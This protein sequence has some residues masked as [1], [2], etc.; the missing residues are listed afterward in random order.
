MALLFLNELINFLTNKTSSRM[1]VD[2]N[3]GAD[4][5]KV[6]LDIDID[7]IPCDLLAILT[8]DALGE[9]SSDIKGEII[10]SRLD[11]KGRKLDNIKYEVS[12]PNYDKIKTEILN[13]EGC[14]LKGHFFVDAVPGS[15]L[16]TSGFYGGTVQRLASEGL[17]KINAQ[18]KINEISFGETSQRYL[19]WSN[20]GKQIS[21]LSYSLNDVKKKYQQF[22]NV[23]QYYLKIVPTKYLSYKDEINDYQYTYNSYAEKGIHEMPSMHFRYDLS[24]ITVEYK[25]YKE[26]IMNFLINVFAILGGVFTVTG[27][28]DAIIH[29]SVVILLRKADLNK[30]A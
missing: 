27:I 25:L 11:K 14:N 6:N 26:T 29:K 20:F 8:S 21:K 18:H 1:Y 30:I 17:L 9:R 5:L 12:E 22:T 10:K 19:V 16:I 3:R 7:N 24:P 2:V 15:F 28:I 23:Y 4:K 13:N